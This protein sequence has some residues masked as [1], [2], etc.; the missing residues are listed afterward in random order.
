MVLEG[1]PGWVCLMSCS[2]DVLFSA[3]I[4]QW[5]TCR[6][7]DSSSSQA[8]SSGGIESSYRSRSMSHHMSHMS[9]MSAMRAPNAVDHGNDTD[10]KI[11]L[12]T[13]SNT[14]VSTCIASDITKAHTKG[15]VLV[16]TTIHSNTRST[17]NGRDSRE[18]DDTTLVS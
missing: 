3:I 12:I 4:L 1:E 13:L 6:D 7:N 11:S 8:G 5:V 2:A 14:T 16:T 17:T 18:E 10:D 9:H 15:G